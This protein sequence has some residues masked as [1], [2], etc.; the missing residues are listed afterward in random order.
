MEFAFL[1]E[2]GDPGKDGSNHLVLTLMC[3]SDKKEISSIIKE[4]KSRLRESNKGLKFLDKTNGEL[5]FHSFP[6][7]VLLKRVLKKLSKLKITIYSITIVKNKQK[8]EST[9]KQII[10]H[11]LFNHISNP[12]NKQMSIKIIADDNFFNKQETNRFL[13]ETFKSIPIKLKEDNEEESK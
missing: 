10:L 11:R 2:S 5:K 1:D 4:A 13:L 7:K 3:T 12:S 8:I 9:T 6:D